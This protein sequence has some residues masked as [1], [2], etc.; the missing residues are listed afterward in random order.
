MMPELLQVLDLFAVFMEHIEQNHPNAEARS[1]IPGNRCAV[2]KT[3]EE[4]FM[5][6][7]KSR[8]G[9]GSGCTGLSG[10]TAYQDESRLFSNGHFMLLQLSTCLT[11]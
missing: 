1:F 7:A 11:R 8:S 6:N 10:I 3:I 9:I 5:K 2:D 4:T